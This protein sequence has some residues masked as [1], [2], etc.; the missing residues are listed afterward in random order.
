MIDFDSEQMFSFIAP[1]PVCPS[2][3]KEGGLV[4][5]TVLRSNVK[6]QSKE[7]INIDIENYICMNPD[8][9]VAYYN[10][11]NTILKD[12]L[13]RELW[14]KTGTKRI[15][16]CYCNNIDAD[17]LKDAVVNHNLSTWEE[18]TEHYRVK[19]IEKCETLNPTGKCCRHIFR[20]MVM[21]VRL[22]T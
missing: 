22:K 10:S 7:K 17:Q 3:S 19:V 8:C 13:K 4:P 14:Y 5:N 16:A 2:C 1:T 15:I 6:I 11:E 9:D 20:G 18:I 12:E 21:D